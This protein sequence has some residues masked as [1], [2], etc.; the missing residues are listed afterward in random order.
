VERAVKGGGEGMRG[1]PQSRR[2]KREDRGCETIDRMYI[3]V[4]F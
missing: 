3:I 1:V 4:W 2:R